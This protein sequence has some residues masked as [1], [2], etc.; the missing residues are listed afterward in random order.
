M[1]GGHYDYAH[2]YVSDMAETVEKEASHH[3]VWDVGASGKE[4]LEP[5]S[6]EETKDR[7]EMAET[8]KRAAEAMRA[9]EWY[10]SGDSGDW[11][12]VKAAFR[13]LTCPVKS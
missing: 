13:H 11:E 10:D 5:R 2:G 4:S 1:S 3:V 12:A 6:P 9:L 8:L 7:L